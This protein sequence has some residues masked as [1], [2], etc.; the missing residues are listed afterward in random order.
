M[1]IFQTREIEVRAS[2][3]INKRPRCPMDV[4][5]PRSPD[6]YKIKLPSRSAARR[7]F[8]PRRLSPYWRRRAQWKYLCLLTKTHLYNEEKLNGEIK[9]EANTAATATTCTHSPRFHFAFQ[10]APAGPWKFEK[11]TQPP[12]VVFDRSKRRSRYTRAGKCF[13]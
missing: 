9:T 12:R 8:E 4:N 1:K 13:S 6:F 11:E 5:F 10:L 2:S 7:D 3:P